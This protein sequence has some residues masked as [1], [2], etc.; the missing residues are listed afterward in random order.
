M[1]MDHSS[2]KRL[3]WTEQLLRDLEK[4][5]MKAMGELV[6][7]AASTDDPKIRHISGRLQI[8]NDT[9]VRVKE[10]KAEGMERD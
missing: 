3:V 4:S 9:I 2:W 8:L 6:V 1:L 10:E 5:R 7:A